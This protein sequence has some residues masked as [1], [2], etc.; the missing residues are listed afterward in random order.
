MP[1]Y[2]QQKEDLKQ[3][4]GSFFNDPKGQH[5]IAD[6]VSGKTN[7]IILDLDEL[8]SFDPDISNNIIENALT[9][10][11]AALKDAVGFCVSSSGNIPIDNSQISVTGTFPLSLI[12]EIG[13]KNIG[14]I[15]KIHGLINKTASIRPMYSKAVFK[16]VLCGNESQTIVQENP[17]TLTKPLPKCDDGHGGGCGERTQWEAVPQL[18]VLEDSQ[19][20]TIQESYEDILSNK[21]PRPMRCITFKKHLLNF[22][23]C[24]DDVEA[25]CIVNAMSASQKFVKTKFNIIYLEVLAV[26]KRRKDPEAMVFTI[27]EELAFKEFVKDPE[28]YTKMINSLAPSLYGHENEKEAVLLAIFGSPE[29]VRE[30]ITIRGNIHIL[31]VGDPATAKSQLLRSAVELSPRGM[32]AMGRGATAAGL[33]AALHKD[34]DT[35]EWEISAGV[36]VLADEGIAAIDE[37][38]KMREEDR[39]MIHEAMEQ[40]T[41]SIDKAGYHVQMKARTAVIAAA[42]PSLGR[43]DQ[44]KSVF[45]NLPKFPPSLFSRFDLI[46]KVLD[47]PNEQMDREVVDHIIENSDRKSPIDRKLMRKY[48]AYSKRLKPKLSSVAAE[49]LKNYF[50]AVRK[51]YTSDQ[52]TFPFSYRQFEALKRLT[53][54]R[55]RS[56]L[57]PEADA[58]DVECVKRLFDVFLK[59]TVGN[60]VTQLETGQST[61]QTD[62][63]K[64]M[65]KAFKEHD[66]TKNDLR[67]M[68]H[69]D[70]NEKFE[71]AWAKLL[72]DNYVY[73][74]G[75]ALNNQEVY[76][77]P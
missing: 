58:S 72:G 76:G 51:T 62:I 26:N 50:V 71:K 25:I 38:E 44:Y 20:F 10:G 16:C 42:N 7:G 59:D 43:Y 28:F 5:Y 17:W 15:I 12:H 29:E 9:Y 31:M 77:V 68:V 30:D 32:Y 37:I 65:M 35:G 11:M 54:A 74:K 8:T 75:I 18:S 19:E 36:L 2:D 47:I 39:V 49:S 45:E 61:S 33:T 60:D 52:K 48:I 53:L 1:S 41:V 73:R 14:R 24:G 63:L 64:V 6:F 57:K 22:V 46:F 3:Q 21:I 67:N 66:M 55:A 70:D 27:E 13:S 69:C 56:L 34:N 4:L 23:N 40:Q